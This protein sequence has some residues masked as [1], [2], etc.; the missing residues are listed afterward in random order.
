M[1]GPEGEWHHQEDFLLSSLE[2][3][4]W[5]IKRADV[6]CDTA[7]QRCPEPRYILCALSEAQKHQELLC[8]SA[9]ETETAD[10]YAEDSQEEGPAQSWQ[11]GYTG[12]M[13]VA[14]GG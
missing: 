4:T 1:P 3:G 6:G 2:V 12:L 9:R 5:S 14:L 8:L 11:V 13:P 10:G 7:M